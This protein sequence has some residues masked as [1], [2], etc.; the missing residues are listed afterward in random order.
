VYT[1]GNANQTS[2]EFEGREIDLKPTTM[3]TSNIAKGTLQ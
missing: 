3:G 2:L 1:I